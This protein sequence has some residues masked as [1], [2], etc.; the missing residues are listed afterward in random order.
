MKCIHFLFAIYFAVVAFLLGVGS[1]I[2]F[3][4]ETS[5]CQFLTFIENGNLLG[6]YKGKKRTYRFHNSIMGV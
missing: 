1:R 2:F 3:F 4:S 5:E 6:E